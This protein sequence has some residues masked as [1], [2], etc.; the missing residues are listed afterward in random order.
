MDS[1]ANC[2]EQL[3]HCEGVV[4]MPN[5]VGEKIRQI[6]REYEMKMRELDDEHKSETNGLNE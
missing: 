5:L 3:K 1:F 4:Q 2:I 6:V